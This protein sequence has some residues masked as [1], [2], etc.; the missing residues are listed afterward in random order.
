MEIDFKDSKTWWWPSQSNKVNKRVVTP[1][2]IRAQ[3]TG[4][5]QE[6]E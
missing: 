4:V 2:I 3:R 5:T 1:F 6:K